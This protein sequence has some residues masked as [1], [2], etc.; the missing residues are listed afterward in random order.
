MPQTFPSFIS[1]VG[2][3]PSRI[4]AIAVEIGPEE[5]RLCNQRLVD[6][7]GGALGSIDSK[8]LKVLS[9]SASH[10][11][12]T[13]RLVVRAS[14]ESVE[15]C[16]NGALSLEQVR[17]RDAVFAEHVE[18]GLTWRVIAK[19][20]A[21]TFPSVLQLVQAPQNATLQKSESETQLLR[22]IFSLAKSHA[23]PDFQS[24]RKVA[25]SAKPLAASV[26][27]PCT[28]L[29]SAFAGAPRETFRAR[30]GFS[31]EVQGTL[32]PWA[33][34]SGKCF[35]KT[36]SKGKSRSLTSDMD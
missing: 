13:L 35:P 27:R 21:E 29:L 20:V 5:D 18:L 17:A 23:S 8:V 31:S 28:V 32:G 1:Q 12:W 2:F 26:S 22:R 3:V 34:H 36:S 7:A 10:T 6:G 9:L 19:E 15:L 16:V 14:H 11:N 4:D 30:P 24:I 33:L 25:L